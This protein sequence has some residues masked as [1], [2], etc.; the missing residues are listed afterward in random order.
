MS[1][2]PNPLIRLATRAI[3]ATLRGLNAVRRAFLSI[4]RPTGPFFAKIGGFLGKWLIR[5]LYR[6]IMTIRLRINKVS[7]TTRGFLFSVF[8]N[9]YAFHAVLLV[10]TAVSVYSQLQAKGAIALDAGQR[11]LLYTLVTDGRDTIVEE[12]VYTDNTV[13]NTQ[14]LADAGVIEAVPAIDFD[15][16]DSEIADTSVPG[17]IAVL[18]EHEVLEGHEAITLTRTKTEDYVVKE[19]DVIGSIARD[20]GVNV[21]TILWANNLTVR[22]L[23]KPGMTLRIPP[24]SGVLHKV[25]KNETLSKVAKLYGVDEEAITKAN[26]LELNQLSVGAELIIPGG[27]PVSSATPVAVK[28]PGTSI[29]AD[30]PISRI[31]GKAVDVYQEISGKDDSRP[32]PAD[33]VEDAPTTKLLWPT[34]L[35]QINQYYGWN[36]TGLDIEGDYTDPIYASEDGVVTTSGWNSGGYGMQIIIEHPNGFK[37]RYAHASKIFVKVGQKV[38]RGEVIPMVGTTGRSTGTHLHYEV[39]LNGIRLNP[40]KYT[41]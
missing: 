11:S 26:N 7:V 37:T 20:Y 9:R 29:K 10:I 3:L 17:S 15:Y 27:S 41:K 28:Q 31:A 18:P 21:G 14:Y 30:V 16:G 38:K 24:V 33:I 13:N 22:S 5:P 25:A 1:T 8:T 19:G 39:Y 35:R 6:L 23:I 12:R 32:K 34:R 4:I 2:T 36:H 40:L